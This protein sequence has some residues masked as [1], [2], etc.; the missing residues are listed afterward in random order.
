MCKLL[1]IMFS[2]GGASNDFTVEDKSRWVSILFFFFYSTFDC[3]SQVTQITF[4]Q[5]KPTEH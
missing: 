4:W 2:H 3:H 1:Q 5:W